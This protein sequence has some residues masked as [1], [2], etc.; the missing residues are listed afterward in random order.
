MVKHKNNINGQTSQTTVIGNK[1][2]PPPPVFPKPHVKTNNKENVTAS[3]KN[4][5]CK[6]N[7]LKFIFNYF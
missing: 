4:N 5:K 7:F 2:Q 3:S 6:N 1:K